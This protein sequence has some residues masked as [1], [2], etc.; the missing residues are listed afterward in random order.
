MLE[1]MIII[2]A[3]SKGKEIFCRPLYPAI[4]YFGLAIQSSAWSLTNAL[5]CYSSLGAIDLVD[6]SDR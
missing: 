6:A 2:K 4:F 3:G 1:L 5:A